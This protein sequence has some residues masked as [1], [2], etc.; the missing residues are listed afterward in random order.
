MVRIKKW[1]NKE[2]LKVVYANNLNYRYK[3]YRFKF[4]LKRI[5]LLK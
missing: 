5:Y 2:V 1:N 4:R 3:Q